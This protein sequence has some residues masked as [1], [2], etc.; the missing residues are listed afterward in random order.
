[1]VISSYWCH[2]HCTAK[3]LAT[4]ASSPSAGPIGYIGVFS[5]QD[6][7][8]GGMR[9]GCVIRSLSAETSVVTR[10]INVDSQESG[11]ET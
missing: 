9:Q 7:G 3:R 4:L 10:I 11:H 1:M 8:A 6:S 2:C 5:A